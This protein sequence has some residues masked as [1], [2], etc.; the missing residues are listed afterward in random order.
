MENVVVIGASPKQDRYSNKAIRMLTQYQHNPIPV[1]P[2]HREIEGKR[3][4]FKQTSRPQNYG[5]KMIL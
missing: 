4:L 2:G 5:F 3:A 1:A